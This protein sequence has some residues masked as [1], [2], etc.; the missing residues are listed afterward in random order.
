[1]ERKIGETPSLY[2]SI[3]EQEFADWAEKDWVGKP[4]LKPPRWYNE[5]TK[6]LVTLETLIVLFK[7]RLN[8]KN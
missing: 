6:E 3:N 1:M 2:D 5:K 7:N 4:E 8:G